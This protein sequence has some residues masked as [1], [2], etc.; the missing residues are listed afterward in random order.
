METIRGLFRNQ[1]EENPSSSEIW[2]LQ[3]QAE[4]S[5]GPS[6]LEEAC[7]GMKSERH[8]GEAG[9]LNWTRPSPLGP[10]VIQGQLEAASVIHL[11]FKGIFLQRKGGSPKCPWRTRSR[12]GL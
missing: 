4:S 2:V 8:E 7:L 5:G 3:K 9:P 11:Q 6:A 10:T 12:A 1:V